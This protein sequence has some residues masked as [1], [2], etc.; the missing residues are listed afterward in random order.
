MLFISSDTIGHLKIRNVEDI[1]KCIRLPLSNLNE[2]FS[3]IQGRFLIFVSNRLQYTFT[4]STVYTY[5]NLILDM[6]FCIV[7]LDVSSN[8]LL[9]IF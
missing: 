2:L 1:F 4:P 6:I 7:I 3:L 8:K 9:R 5:A